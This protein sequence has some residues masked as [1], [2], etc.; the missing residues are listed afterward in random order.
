M[1]PIHLF[2]LASR[3]ARWAAVRQATIAGNVANADTPGYQARDIV[4]FSAVLQK[5]AL[6]LARTEPGH[7]DVGGAS[8]IEA[9]RTSKADNW[10]ITH[11]GNSVSLDQELLK[12]GEV[13]RAYTLNTNIVRSFH[14]M[15]LSSVRSGT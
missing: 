10:D 11:S 12:A 14:K 1:E 6:T 8:G 4:P 15:L 2:D 3:Q 9:N 5:T 7:L 13:S